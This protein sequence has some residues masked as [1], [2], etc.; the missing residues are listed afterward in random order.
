M[1]TFKI[2]SFSN[3]QIYNTVLLTIVT[4]LHI[5]SL[6]LIFFFKIFIYLLY[7]WLH[8]VLAAASRIFCCSRASFSV[9]V[10]GLSSCP[11]ACGNLSS[12][13]RDQ[14]C[15]PCIGRLI[16]NHWTAM[17][18]P[19]RTYNW[20]C[21][22]FDYCQMTKLKQFSNKFTVPNS[23]ENNLWIGG[24]QNLTSSGAPFP[25]DFE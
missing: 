10:L 24:V 3:F 19:T 11:E 22:P 12:P 2:Y 9:V 20:K 16:L 25:K 6:E 21:V 4:T 7:F 18:V 17:E 8:R 13:I 15:I 14:T 5:T 1:R 23:R